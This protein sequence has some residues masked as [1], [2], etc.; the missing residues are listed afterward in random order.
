MMDRDDSGQQGERSPQNGEGGTRSAGHGDRPAPGDTGATP[1]L[2]AGEP[3]RG[4]VF[5]R[6]VIYRVLHPLEAL[7]ELLATVVPSRLFVAV[8]QWMARPDR[9]AAARERAFRATA[10]GPIVPAGE[11]GRPVVILLASQEEGAPTGRDTAI[12]RE[13]LSLGWRVVRLRATAARAGRVHLTRDAES[14]EEILWVPAGTQWRPDSGRLGRQA[15]GKM[16]RAVVSCANRDGL[17]LGAVVCTSGFWIDLAT[18]LRAVMN[19]PVAV[20]AHDGEGGEDTG[21]E[22]WADL[23]MTGQPLASDDGSEPK[24]GDRLKVL[25][26]LVSIVIAGGDPDGRLEQQIRSRTHYPNYEIVTGEKGDPGGGAAPTWPD[27]MQGAWTGA[28]GELLCFVRKP[29][30]LGG[31]WLCEL[32]QRMRM[33]P[34]AGL[35][36]P[37]RNTGIPGIRT[38]SRYVDLAGF[39]AWVKKLRRV[40]RHNASS[41]PFVP[42]SCFMIRRALLEEIGGFDRGLSEEFLG[43]VDLARRVRRAG[44]DIQ[45]VRGSYIHVAQLRPAVAGVPYTAH[46]AER[47]LVR[48]RYRRK[49]AGRWKRWVGHGRPGGAVQP[50]YDSADRPPAMIAELHELMRYRDLVHLLTISNIKTRYKRSVLGVGWTLLNPLLHMTVLTL[51]FS[52]VFK[53]SI[54]DY[55]VYVLSGLIVWNFFSQITTQAMT[56]VISGGN[57]MRQIYIPPSVFC[58]ATATAG[59]V[60]LGLSLIPLILIM[61]IM[62]HPFH[63]ALVFVPLAVLAL[64]LFS[65][66]VALMLGTL[67]VFFTDLVELYG[68]LLR[69]GYFLTAV[70]YPITVIP[71]KWR[72]VIKINPVYSYICCFRDPIY[73]GTFPSWQTFAIAG[74]SGVLVLIAGWWVLA[75]KAHEIVYRT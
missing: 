1:Q 10:E 63:V 46:P 34:H 55:P 12:V 58:V 29:V 68:V 47:E 61:V 28:R 66:G 8:A 45:C 16:A 27:R 56:A 71:N 65:L 9:R 7:L 14:G 26:P 59:L 6:L 60:N 22:R 44:F 37:A 53:S 41:V 18:V 36:T 19:W 15:L 3:N 70:M 51:A 5:L 48:R 74:V 32:V 17:G 24:L 23:D 42:L 4:R 72:W 11:D 13:L 64:F 50:V 20:V 39:D 52:A 25:F 69:A 35:V 30:V 21:W 38:R 43:A 49:W 31:G 73:A 57:L 67:A 62:G 54:T 33:D 75:R 2:G 40:S